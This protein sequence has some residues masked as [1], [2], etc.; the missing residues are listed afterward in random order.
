MLKSERH[1]YIIDLLTQNNYATVSEIS[2]L[3]NVSKMTIRRDVSELSK[4][5]KVIRLFGGVQLVDTKEKEFSTQEKITLHIDRKKHI[6]TVM[7]DLIEDNSTIYVGAGTTIFYALSELTKKNLFIITNSLIAFNY[8]IEHT[9]HQVILSG[10]QLNKNTEE[11]IGEIA[12]RIFENLNI[13]I[14]FS[15][16]NGIYQDNIT[17]SSILEGNI[18]RKAFEHCKVKVV[19]SD[20]SKFNVTDRFTFCHLSEIDYVITDNEIT[21]QVKEYYSKFVEIL[22]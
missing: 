11:F 15:A 7:N 22:N 19:V 21:P 12:E 1:Q 8:L 10:G 13:D 3:L 5:N 2:E 16:T 14:G 18:Q 6:G 9:E 4:E 20:S 17:T